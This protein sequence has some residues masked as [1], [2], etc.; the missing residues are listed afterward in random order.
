[1][2]SSEI[3]VGIVCLLCSLPRRGSWL[4]GAGRRQDREN[5]LYTVIHSKVATDP[6]RTKASQVP[7]CFRSRLPN[8]YVHVGRGRRQEADHS[9]P[10]VPLRGP[11]VHPQAAGAFVSSVN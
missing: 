9:C 2:S 11:H 7:P 1:M 8:D 6:T 3:C 4:E 5:K 10:L